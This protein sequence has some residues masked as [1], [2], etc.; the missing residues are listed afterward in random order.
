MI[1][2]APGAHAAEA[3]G[4][5]HVSI[6]WMSVTNIYYEIGPL[7]I[8]TDGFIS[9]I[10]REEFYGG[11]GG[12]AFTR[13]SPLPHPPAGGRGLAPPGGPAAGG[14]VGYRRHPRGHFFFT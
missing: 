9:R 13:P 1:W 11:G 8:L 7:H 14:V 12:H 3:T 10:P 6:T 5:D 2:A 4:P